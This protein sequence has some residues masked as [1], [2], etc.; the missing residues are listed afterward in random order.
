MSSVIS[1]ARANVCFSPSPTDDWSV[2][3]IVGEG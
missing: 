2:P 3:A 1:R